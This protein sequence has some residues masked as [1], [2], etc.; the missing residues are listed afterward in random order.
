[1]IWHRLVFLE[2]GSLISLRAWIRKRLYQRALFGGLQTAPCLGKIGIFPWT[3]E[4]FVLLGG[5]AVF[6]DALVADPW[7]CCLELVSNSWRDGRYCI[8]ISAWGDVMAAGFGKSLGSIPMSM[9]AAL[10]KYS[11]WIFLHMYR[12]CFVVLPW[13]LNSTRSQPWHMSVKPP[14][15]RTT[16]LDGMR[17]FVDS[18][19]FRRC[20]SPPGHMVAPL[21]GKIAFLVLQFLGM[22]LACLGSGSDENWDDVCL[23]LHYLACILSRVW[24]KVIWAMSVSMA[25][26]LAFRSFLTTCATFFARHTLDWWLGFPQLL[27][28]CPHAGHFGWWDPV[29]GVPCWWL[30][31]PLQIWRFG[32]AS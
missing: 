28:A 29:P 7:F 31:Q 15:A 1:M 3:L 27:Q 22:S 16:F 30:P 10:L 11:L 25:A 14:P 4:C 24:L 17:L 32:L 18:P 5:K 8:A 23:Y 19:I 13:I 20:W 12:A 26:S 9:Q 2:L 21:S 6:W